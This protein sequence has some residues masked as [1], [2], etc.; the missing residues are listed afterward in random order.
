MIMELIKAV[1]TSDPQS[2]PE[3][4][5]IFPLGYQLIQRFAVLSPAPSELL[6]HTIGCLALAVGVAPAHVTHQIKQT[7][8]LP[9]LTENIGNIG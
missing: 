6:S 9:F 2:V 5:E 3:F 4:S 8:L 1:M 7:G